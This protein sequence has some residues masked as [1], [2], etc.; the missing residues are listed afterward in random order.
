LKASVLF[1]VFFAIV[2]VLAIT[3]KSPSVSVNIGKATLQ[4]EASL[5][6]E[7]FYLYAILIGFAVIVCLVFWYF[8]RLFD[9]EEKTRKRVSNK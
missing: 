3:L 6:I 5:S 1:L 9:R 2:L 4:N 8:N 7:S